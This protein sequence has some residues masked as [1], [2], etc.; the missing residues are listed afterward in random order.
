MKILF[1]RF[2]KS[3]GHSHKLFEKIPC[4]VLDKP[5]KTAKSPSEKL[6]VSKLVSTDKVSPF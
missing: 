5:G 3:K 2:S 6:V 1:S 4:I